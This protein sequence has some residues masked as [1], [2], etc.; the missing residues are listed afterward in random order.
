[1]SAESSP[2]D[3]LAEAVVFAHER[4]R[5][6]PPFVP[7]RA[8]LERMAALVSLALAGHEP[9]PPRLRRRLL[10]AGLAHCSRRRGERG[11]GP[12]GDPPGAGGER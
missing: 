10:A 4:V 7:E 1:M 11:K 5:A 12:G 8:E 6:L 2:L 9:V 3:R